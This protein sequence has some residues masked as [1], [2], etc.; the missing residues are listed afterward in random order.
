MND[1]IAQYLETVAA[2]QP[3][4]W[5]S[6]LAAHPALANDLAAFFADHDGVK[7]LAEPLRAPEPVTRSE[8]ETKSAAS[9]LGTV[10]Y[11]GDYEPLEEI[12]RG[13]MGIVY[14]G[15]Q[16]SLNRLVAL[17]IILAGHLAAPNDVQR[18]RT[19][20]KAAANLDHPNIVP[21]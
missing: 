7:H 18:F 15:R 6:L 20:A 5:Q 21:I 9:S 8:A 4:D 16:I 2:G 13:G 14:K 1:L 10:R 17:K 11:F 12:V 3:P 19:E